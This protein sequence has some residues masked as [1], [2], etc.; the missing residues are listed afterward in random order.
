MPRQAGP[1]K[2]KKN[3][4]L[5]EHICDLTELLLTPHGESSPAHGAWSAHI[6]TLM[7]NYWKGLAPEVRK[8]ILAQK[9]KKDNKTRKLIDDLLPDTS[10][11]SCQSTQNQ[12]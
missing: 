9:E 1:H 6:E 11:L 5:E 7:Y 10:I 2:I 3:L 4:Y 12:P 8:A